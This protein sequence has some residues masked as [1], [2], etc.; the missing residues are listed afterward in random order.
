MTFSE[1]ETVNYKKGRKKYLIHYILSGEREYFY[2]NK[3]IV[4]SCDTLVFIPDKS[5]YK[6]KALSYNNTP[7]SGIGISFYAD[8]K[9]PIPKGIFFEKVDRSMID[10]F[11]HAEKYYNQSPINYFML[12][13]SIWQI[14]CEVEKKV[15]KKNSPV[16]SALEFIQSTYYKNY[17]VSEY[18][19]IC[20]MSESYFRKKF[21]EYMGV[22]PLKYRNQLRLTEARRLYKEGYSLAQ[23][24]E[25]VGFEDSSYLSKLYK[26]QT[27]SSL[28]KEGRENV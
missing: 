13:K 22:S 28:T 14:F 5:I 6:T 8:K 20:A 3:K 15:T 18:A 7:C 24:A 26:K 17:P 25:R 11:L 12:R 1:G 19:R 27:N 9:L 16:Y 23:I 4:L 10:F 21:H 2:E